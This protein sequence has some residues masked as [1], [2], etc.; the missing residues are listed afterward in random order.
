MFYLNR[1]DDCMVNT[2]KNCRFVCGVFDFSVVLNK[3]NQEASQ[4]LSPLWLLS[5]GA[6][7]RKLALVNAKKKKDIRFLGLRW[8]SKNGTFK[9][10]TNEHMSCGCHLVSCAIVP[11]VPNAMWTLLPSLGIWINVAGEH[12]IKKYQAEVFFLIARIANGE[13]RPTVMDGK[14]LSNVH[15]LCCFE[16]NAP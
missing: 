8:K 15:L 16:E 12:A 10:L 1:I 6:V 14:V 11:Q 7:H 13:I 2:M 4:K 3:S 5:S 9:S